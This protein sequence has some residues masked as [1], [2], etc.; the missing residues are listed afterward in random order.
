MDHLAPVFEQIGNAT[1]FA[2][3]AAVFA[4]GQPQIRRSAVAVFGERFHQHCH[5]TGAIALVAH[6]LQLS[7]IA[8]L[9][10]AFGDGSLDV[11]G[12]DSQRL[13]LC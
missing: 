4:E 12:G 3:I 11:G 2:E 13:G 5:A 9:A 8:R 7:P 6:L 1:V 10:G